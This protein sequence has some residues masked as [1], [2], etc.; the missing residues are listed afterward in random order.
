MKLISII[1]LVGLALGLAAAPGWGQSKAPTAPDPDLEKL[2]KGNNEFAFDLYRRLSKAEGNLIFSP[3]SIS[4]ALA[5][6]YA[7]ARGETAEQMAKVL[8][9]D[10]GQE[11]THPALQRLTRMLRADGKASAFEL[12]LANALWGQ[13]GFGFRTD[14]LQLLRRHHEAGFNEVDFL[15]DAAGARKII[16][17]WVEKETNNRIKDL[18]APSDVKPNTRLV[19]TNAVYFKAKWMYPF[20]IQGNADFHIGPDKLISV[21]MMEVNRPFKYWSCDEFQLV[22]LPYRND[23]GA[24]L[25]AGD[26]CSML[27]FLPPKQGTLKKLEQ[28]LTASKIDFGVSNLKTH[29]GKVVLPRFK[30]QVRYELRDKLCEMGM[31]IPFSDQADF[32]G[33]AARGLKIDNVIHKAHVKVDEYGTEAAAATVVMMVTSSFPPFSLTA[34]RP[35]LF[36]IRDSRTG[37][38][39]FMGRVVEP[40]R[41]L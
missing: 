29:V 15:G 32:S 9:F 14:F 41:T 3:Y 19:L 37:S 7:G 2:V 26:Y 4:T 5:M 8:H 33:M 30:A 27:V 21:P 18:L 11:G 16:N 36:A 24:I 38:I 40:D 34:D 39:L 31:A 12:C 17:D 25:L 1:A 10:L 6:T 20:T 23:P 13:K 28:S 22:E 35:F